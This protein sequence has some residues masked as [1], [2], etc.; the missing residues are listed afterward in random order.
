M[1]KGF[2]NISA[3]KEDS[4]TTEA[5]VANIYTHSETYPAH[6]IHNIF[7]DLSLKREKDSWTFDLHACYHIPTEGEPTGQIVTN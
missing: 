3:W 5:T 7:I 1:E 4:T 6:T 2:Y